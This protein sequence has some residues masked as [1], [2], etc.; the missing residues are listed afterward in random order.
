MKSNT[1]P[2]KSAVIVCHDFIYG[3]PHE[4]RDFMISEGITELLFIG[5]VNR[6]V[7]K[8]FLSQSYCEH[9]IKGKCQNKYLA[10]K[11]KLPEILSYVVDSYYSFYWSVTKL[12]AID[13]YIGVGNL[14]ALMG[15]VLMLLHKTN[16][17]IYYVIDYAIMRFSNGMLNFVYHLLDKICAQYSNSTWNYAATMIDKRNV[18]W[19][20]VF[21]NQIVVP[22]GIRHRLDIIVPYKLCNK[23]EIVY[24]GT[25]AGF[26]GVDMVI[27]ALPRIREIYPD[28]VFTIIG[29]GKDKI[30]LKTL[31][32]KL[33]V[34]NVVNFLG[35]IE[36]PRE[37]E[38][39]IAHA[40][41]GVACYDTSHPLVFTT[42][43]GK[44]KRYLACGIPVMMTDVS[45]IAKGIQGTC[46][47]VISNDLKT[48]TSTI[49]NFFGNEKLMN[50]YRKNAFQYAKDFQWNTIFRKAFESI[51]K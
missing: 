6:Y 43:P 4:L 25:L 28:T 48:I 22:N 44:V 45:P 49:I 34:I 24:M 19:N 33:K 39:R 41:L 40:S 13:I 26:Q 2:Y 27:K 20:H 50:L 23:H 29:D 15:L 18:K 35:F 38:Q 5:H 30:Q 8:N 10:L 9:W 17:S 51:E 42:E 14:N 3:P 21:R 32:K 37:M 1:I 31:A 11:L 46:G 47:F 12:K 7:S 16:V 36:D